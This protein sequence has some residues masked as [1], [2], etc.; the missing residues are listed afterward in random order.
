ME[1]SNIARSVKGPMKINQS[2][3]PDMDGCQMEYP[4]DSGPM[5]GIADNT[6]LPEV[7]LGKDNFHYND[8]HGKVSIKGGQNV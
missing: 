5:F 3:D 2:V 7:A 1:G 4:K 8:S 6:T